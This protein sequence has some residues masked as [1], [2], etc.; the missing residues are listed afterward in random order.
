M[1]VWRKGGHVESNEIVQ[2]VS[3]ST[4]KPV[5]HIHATILQHRRLITALAAFTRPVVNAD[6]FVSDFHIVSWKRLAV[7][8]PNRTRTTDSVDG[9]PDCFSVA[10]VLL[11]LKVYPISLPIHESVRLVVNFHF[12]LG[13]PF[14]PAAVRCRAPGRAPMALSCSLTG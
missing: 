6:Y 7:G 3:R 12:I 1:N 2:E 4:Y 10:T 5:Y 8:A 13:D 11:P 9:Q 14:S